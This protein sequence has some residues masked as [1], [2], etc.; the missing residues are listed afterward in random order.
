VNG[1][2]VV[3]QGSFGQGGYYTG[4][5]CVT[6]NACY[7]LTGRDSYGDGIGNGGYF[8]MTVDGERA[9]VWGSDFLVAGTASLGDDCPPS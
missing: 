7:V 8:A 9:V 3:N 2:T 6:A 1:V 4:G 5:L